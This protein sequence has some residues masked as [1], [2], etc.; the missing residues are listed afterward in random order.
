MSLLAF[1][2]LIT[3]KMEIFRK[4]VIMLMLHTE[5]NDHGVYYGYDLFLCSWRSPIN[6]HCDRNRLYLTEC[7]FALY[8]S[9]I[10]IVN[11]YRWW[12]VVSHSV[13]VFS[14]EK[15]IWVMASCCSSSKT[16]ATT[17]NVC[18]CVLV[19]SNKM[20]INWINWLSICVCVCVCP[21]YA[22]VRLMHTLLYHICGD[23]LRAAK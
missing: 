2:Q 6:F 8:A 20:L 15:C 3:I 7:V 21:W 11:A 9:Q 12:L 4:Y 1:K 18:V 13:V 5:R 14:V 16:S 23:N 22:C 10:T 19:I 17:K